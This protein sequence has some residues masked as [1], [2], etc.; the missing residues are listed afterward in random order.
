MRIN[1]LPWASVFSRYRILWHILF[2][3]WLYA[4]DVFI[5]GVG[6]ANVTLFLKFAL[7][8]MPG[9]LFFA[10]AVVYWVLPRYFKT[11]RLVEMFVLLFAVFVITGLLGHFL[12]VTTASY[13]TEVT[14]WDLPKIFL[15]AFYSFLKACI[16]IVI[17]LVIVW[18]QSQKTVSEM[19]QNRLASELKM[20][21]DQVNPHFMFNTFNNLYG[22]IRKDPL[23]AQES[24]LG[25][26][27]I[28]HY[29]LYDS[30]QPTVPV[31]RELQCIEDYIELE[32][33]RYQDNLSVSINVQEQ[34]RG[35]AIVPLSLF[36]FVENSFKHGASEQISEAWINIDLSV[37]KNDFI[38]KIEN[39]KGVRLNHTNGHGIGLTNVK[40]RLELLY[41]SRHKLQIIEGDERYLVVLKIFLTEMTPQNVN[42]YESEMS[43]RRG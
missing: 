23:R 39:S 18:Y 1:S 33:L 29:M 22:L 8:E 5:F 27:G 4:L 6:Y 15:R 2:W 3:T 42:T 26:S 14:W 13:G 19:E 28:L 35:L 20:L 43:Y 34:V 11:Q 25:F 17:K 10:Y 16:F 37:F 40:R 38:F 24:V 21:K 7:L 36:P 30:N 31:Q 9:Q 12:F 41:G 32:K